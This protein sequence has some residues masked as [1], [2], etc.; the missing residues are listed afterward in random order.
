MATSVNSVCLVILVMQQLL[1]DANHA[2]VMVM[3]I[4][5]RICVMCQQDNVFAWISLWV[6]TVVCVSLDLKEIQSMWCRK[7]DDYSILT[8]VL[9]GDFHP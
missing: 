4:Q 2:S 6:H 9:Y 3:V 8:G 1:K 5:A 7:N